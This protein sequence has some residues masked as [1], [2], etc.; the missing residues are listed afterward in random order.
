MTTLSYLFNYA[1]PGGGERPA[2]YHAV[3]LLL[4]AMNVL[5][6][7]ALARRVTADVEGPAKAGHYVR[8]NAS[9]DARTDVVSGFSRTSVPF[10][11]AAMWAVHPLT[12]E[13]VTN[14]VGRADLLAAFGTLGA[15]LAYVR[16][17]DARGMARVAWLGALATGVMI[18]IGSKESGV[19]IVAAIAL[20]ELTWWRPRKSA[21]ALA[22]ALVVAAI[23]LAIYFSQRAAVLG[24]APAAEFPFADNPIAGA[25]FWQGR[26]TAI[27]V[28]GRYLWLAIWPA[29]L[30]ADY[31]YGQIPLARTSADWLIVLAVVAVAGMSVAIARRS[32]AVGFFAAFAFLTLLPASNLLVISG[33]IMA[34]RLM[35][36]PL[37]GLAVLAAMALTCAL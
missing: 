1:V 12:T 8:T 25:G 32:R 30:S 28:I 16:S 22:A 7:Y 18:A 31:S 2:G 13:A 9:T 15:L 10:L 36:L 21:G 23:P 17:R 20:Y 6:L 4:H 37:A 35:Y 33:T 24:S 27:E 5:L 34:E 11:A 19:V 29:R 3:N 26:L 14:I